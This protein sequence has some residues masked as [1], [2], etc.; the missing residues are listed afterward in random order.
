MGPVW[1]ALVN[2]LLND[3]TLLVLLPDTILLDFLERVEFV[4]V[5]C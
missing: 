5:D 2:H 4:M 1:G 3:S